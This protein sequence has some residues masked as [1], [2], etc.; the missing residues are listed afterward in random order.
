MNFKGIFNITKDYILSH[1]REAWLTGSLVGLGL[2]VVTT[3]RATKKTMVEYADAEYDFCEENGIECK[4][5]KQKAAKIVIKNAVAPAVTTLTTGYCMVM[6]YK[7]G[8]KQI[9]SGIMAV[10]ALAEMREVERIYHDKVREKL[11]DKEERKLREEVNKKIVEDKKYDDGLVYNTGT[12]NT[13]MCC[14]FGGGYFRADIDSIYKGFERWS[15]IVVSGQEDFASFNELYYYWGLENTQAGDILGCFA[16]NF[17][18]E[19]KKSTCVGPNG[20]PCLVWYI[21]EEY[22]KCEMERA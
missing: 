18:D 9:Q 10:N 15:N 16:D 12:G 20:E 14:A 19:L 17:P 1:K 11:G 5:P 4:L 7:E 3:V 22:I 13:L 6:G 8:S 21:E 2:T